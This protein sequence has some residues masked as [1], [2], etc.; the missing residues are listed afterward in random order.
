MNKFNQLKEVKSLKEK[1]NL[2]HWSWLK[3]KALDLDSLKIN[4]FYMFAHI[5]AERPI[6]SKND[7]AREWLEKSVCFFPVAPVEVV[8]I[9][10]QRTLIEESGKLLHLTDGTN[11]VTKSSSTYGKEWIL[12]D[13]NLE[14]TRTAEKISQL[15]AIL[16]AMEL[17][18]EL[19]KISIPN[20]NFPSIPPGIGTGNPPFAPIPGT[21]V[22]PSSPLI[23]PNTNPTWIGGPNSDPY[24]ITWGNN[25]G[26]LASD[27]IKLGEFTDAAGNKITYGS[28]SIS[29]SSIKG[30]SF[31]VNNCGQF[32]NHLDTSLEAASN[33]LAAFSSVLSN[34]V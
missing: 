20:I 1:A 21:P 18:D 34:I 19:D 13:A 27:S 29:L 24:K 10:L 23:T 25:S 30:S 15:N 6:N 14:V 33:N 2:L 5:A 26:G 3:S 16:D 7:L 17:A 31:S 4:C 28:N 12:C 22:Q 11:I 8:D 32:L 9:K